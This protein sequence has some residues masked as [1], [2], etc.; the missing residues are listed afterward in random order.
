[1]WLLLFTFL[2]GMGGKIETFPAFKTSRWPLSHRPVTRYPFLLLTPGR[3]IATS[4]PSS[5]ISDHAA[6]ANFSAVMLP[7]Q[8][9]L[10][11]FSQRPV[12]TGPLGPERWALK[13][14]HRF[15]FLSRGFKHGL[16]FGGFQE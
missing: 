6:L 11:G 14:W 1:M 7:A 5:P 9:P 15:V 12:S 16:C 4:I 13:P 3:A 8:V 10:R 2:L